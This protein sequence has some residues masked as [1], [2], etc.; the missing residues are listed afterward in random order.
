MTIQMLIDYALQFVGT[1]Y[2]WGGDDAIKGYDCSGFLQE[3][4]A[5]VGFDPPGDQTAHH[6][7]SFFLKHGERLEIPA[8]GAL[9]FFGTEEKCTHCAMAL[10]RDLMIEAAG[11]G[12]KT[13]SR[14]KAIQHNA[15]VRMRPI[16]LRLDLLNII[17]PNYQFLSR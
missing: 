8:P 9:L 15:Y 6:L 7:Q 16:E 1:P 10:T 14:E 2:I 12:S 17:M 3:L 13:T 5:S 4:L 11:G